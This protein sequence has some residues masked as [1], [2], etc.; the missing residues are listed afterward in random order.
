MLLLALVA[1]C[2]GPEHYAS[3]PFVGFPGFIADTHTFNRNPNKPPGSQETELESEGKVSQQA[4]LLP[5]GGNVWPGPAPLDPTLSDVG[6]M[7]ANPGGQQQLTP[8]NPQVVPTVPQELP[9]PHGESNPAG[10]VQ[11]APQ[12]APFGAVPG[13]PVSPTRPQPPATFNTPAGPLINN[14]RVGVPG[15]AST[16]VSPLNGGQNI[17]VPN[18]NGTSTIIAPDGSTQIVPSK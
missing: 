16:A 6:R 2:A 7:L 14:G 18:G 11:T 17:V 1:G 8:S 10:S 3:S 4:V 12:P 9:L 15:G 13:A 5:E